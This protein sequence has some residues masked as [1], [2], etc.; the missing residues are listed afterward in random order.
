MSAGPMAD[1]P[2]DD[3]LFS[4]DV[5]DYLYQNYPRVAPLFDASDLH[6]LFK[7]HNT[8]ANAAKQRSKRWGFVAVALGFLSLAL[9]SCSP[10]LLR[11][12]GN[13]VPW[14]STALSAGLGLVISVL[15]VSSV[16]IGYTQR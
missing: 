11:L 12:T 2:N 5:R 9:A 6:E 16:V 14:A 3:L 4:P 13:L 15:A 10:L 8:P 1:W 7:A